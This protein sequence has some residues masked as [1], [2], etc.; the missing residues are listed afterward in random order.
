VASASGSQPYFRESEKGLAT[1][2]RAAAP[3]TTTAMSHFDLIIVGTGSAGLPAG[4]YASRYKIKNLV[5]GKEPG[6]ALATSHRVENWPGELGAS[7]AEIMGRFEAHAKASGSE[8]LYGSVA[9]ITTPKPHFFEVKTEAGEAFTSDFVILA[10]GN[11][12]RHLGVPGEDRLLGAGVSYCA[13]CDGNFFRKKEVVMVGG[14]DAAFT[15]ALYLAELCAKV[16]IL[17]RGDKA[18]A[19]DIWVE[20]AKANPKVEI[21]YNAV[22]AEILGAM[23]VEGVQLKDGSVVKC[24]GVFVA[25]GSLPQTSLVDHLG[26]A[27]DETGCIVV[28][29]AQR[30]NVPGLFAAGDITTGSHKFRQTIM[31]AA[32]GCLAAHC[33]HEEMLKR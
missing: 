5:I 32:E 19:E 15:E 2:Q 21:R 10:T 33:V 14:G 4:M 20:K 29:A 26:V 9:S 23:K 27:K 22:P 7:G 1:R 30:T 12:Y 25:I 17:I 8:V 24:D 18:R 13:T 3:F 28:D 6:G 11:G 16:T 31:S